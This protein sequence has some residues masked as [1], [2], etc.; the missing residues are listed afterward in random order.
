[1]KVLFHYAAGPDLAARLAAVPRLEIAVCP[2]DDDALLQRSLPDAD[3]LWHVLRPCTAAMIGAA[4]RLKLIQK[5]GVGV[6]TIDLEAA[7]ARGIPVCNLPGT[8]ARAVAELTLALMLATL[9]RL[10]R[11]DA[12]MRQGVWSDP[13]LQDG[14]GELGGRVVGLVGYGAIPRLLA[15]VLA[16]LGCRLLYTTRVA[17][18][19]ALGEWRC[20]PALLDEADVVSLHVPLTAETATLID[21]A[22]LARMK[23]G[24]VLINTARGGLVDQAALTEALCSG[25]LA[26]AGLDVFEA[27]PPGF[28]AAL[29]RLPNVVLSPHVG[30]LTTGTFDRSFALAAENCRRVAAGEALLHRVV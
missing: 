10:P 11:F 17:K 28:A 6:N 7:Q 27:E 22:A 8:N 20:L 13:L 4:P 12:A 21:A 26:A 14:L 29:F 5:I 9:R 16:A 2:E 1:M 23:P 19:A 3:V 24:A 18:P 30:W 15:P 25:R